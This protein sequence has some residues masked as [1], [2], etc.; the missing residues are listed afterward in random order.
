MFSIWFH[1][2]LDFYIFACIILILSLQRHFRTQIT[3][4]KDTY[5]LFGK[6]FIKH[7]L[8]MYNPPLSIMDTTSYTET[9]LWSLLI[10]FLTS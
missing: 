8:I 6:L 3:S 4:D 2:Q 1:G 10:I 7:I 5:L 9:N